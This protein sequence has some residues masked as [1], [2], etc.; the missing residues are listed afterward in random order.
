MHIRQGFISIISHI[1]SLIDFIVCQKQY[2]NI[3]Y[4][5]VPTST[6][7]Q[8]LLQTNKKLFYNTDKHVYK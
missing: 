5:I 1:L 7:Y 6:Y 4:N 8:W 3:K 2:I